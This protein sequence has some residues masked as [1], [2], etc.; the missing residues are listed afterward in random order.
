MLIVD[1]FV[2]FCLIQKKCGYKNGSVGQE[3]N[4]IDEV[5]IVQGVTI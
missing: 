4:S 2:K 5:S 3:S 1:T